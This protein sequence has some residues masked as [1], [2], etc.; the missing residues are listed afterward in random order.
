[1]I[2]QKLKEAL[3]EALIQLEKYPENTKFCYFPIIISEKAKCPK[4]N[5][6]EGDGYTIGSFMYTTANCKCGYSYIES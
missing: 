4:C 3:K 6:Y 1:M 5:T 2:K